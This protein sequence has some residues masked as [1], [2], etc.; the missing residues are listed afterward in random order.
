MILKTVS[1]GRLRGVALAVAVGWSVTAVAGFQYGT[2]DVG[3]S[4]RPTSNASIGALEPA[5]VGLAVPAQPTG[6]SIEV[7]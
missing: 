1:L 3:G 4:E 6:L 7:R 2:A 5:S